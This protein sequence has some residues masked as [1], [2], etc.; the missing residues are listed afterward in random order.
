MLWPGDLKGV[1]NSGED[2]TPIFGLFKL[3]PSGKDLRFEATL[4]IKAL[5][6]EKKGA[7]Q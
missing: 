6:E 5:M 7:S 2:Q 1:L 3:Y 4:W